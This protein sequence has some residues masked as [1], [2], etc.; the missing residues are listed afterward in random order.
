MKN[1]NPASSPCFMMCWPAA[2]ITWRNAGTAIMTSSSGI[3]L[4]QGDKEPNNNQVRRFC[5]CSGVFWITE[6]RMAPSFDAPPT[7]HGVEIALRRLAKT[8]GG[9][10]QDSGRAS[11]Q[12]SESCLSKTGFSGDT[13]PFGLWSKEIWM[14]PPK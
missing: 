9:A 7:T 3:S 14:A 4:S 10:T 6:P 2:T 11:T 13:S 5:S 12:S 1:S 8:P